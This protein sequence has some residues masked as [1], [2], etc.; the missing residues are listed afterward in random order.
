MNL[1]PRRAP[2]SWPA[3]SVILG[4]KNGVASLQGCLD[5]IAA[6][7]WPSRETIVIDSDSTDGTRKLLETSL[8]EGKV[9]TLVSEPDRG[10]Y[11]AWNKALRRSRGDW[12]CFLGCDDRFHDAQA[13]RS[14]LGAEA[15]GA[16]VIYGRIRLVTPNGVVGEVLGRPWP[17]ARTAFLAGTML[18]HPGTLHHRSLFEEHGFFD[19]SYRIAG[20]YDMLL[21]ELLQREPRF[22]DRIVVD[23][24][25]GGMSSRPGAIY[26]NLHEIQR[27]RA[28]HGLRGTPAR[29]RMALAAAWLGSGI[30]RLLG[31][32]AYGWCADLYRLARGKRRIWTV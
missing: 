14:L 11:E 24:R 7:D 1:L 28:A 20:D 25:F 31:D 3:V 15:D 4:V 29:L 9:S 23:M 16:R 8:R 5:S 6:Q 19:E 17:Q 2:G 27:A 18:P 10:L 26:G 12:V 30:Q 22:V 13:L 21:R 32:R